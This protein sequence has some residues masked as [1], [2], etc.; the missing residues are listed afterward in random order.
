MTTEFQWKLLTVAF[1]HGSLQNR[2]Q[3]VLEST[4][5]C[6]DESSEL[7]SC[8]SVLFLWFLG[9]FFPDLQLYFGVC[10]VAHPSVRS[11]Q[12]YDILFSRVGRLHAILVQF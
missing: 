11:F 2:E 4:A 6:L 10:T 5:Q 9:F 3:I 8:L 12:F 1:I 7:F